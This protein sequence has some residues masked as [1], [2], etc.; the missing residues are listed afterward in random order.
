MN[1][2]FYTD[3]E[4]MGLGIKKMGKNVSISR[5][6]SIY[7]PENIELGDNVRI[8]D[9]CIL[10]GKIKLGSYI[11]IAAYTGIFAG[12]GGVILEDYTGVSSRC[13][14]YALSDD[15]SGE[16]MMN[17]VVPS[18][19]RNV[20]QKEVKIMKYAIIGT[21]CTILPG[22][23]VGEGVAVGAMSLINRNLDAWKIYAGIPCKQIR[24]RRR[25][26]IYKAEDFEE[27]LGRDMNMK[28]I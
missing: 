22:V 2:S 9:F 13:A 28:E 20:T 5:N 26:L 21:G 18:K 11:H 17:P 15:Y 10:S 19:Y 27:I 8:D 1:T 25:E 7:S 14:I 16:Y 4:L 23:I 12:E 6:A 24:E 3:S